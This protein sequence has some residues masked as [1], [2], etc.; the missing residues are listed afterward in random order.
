MIICAEV[1]DDELFREG[2]QYLYRQLDFTSFE[3]ICKIIFMGAN[4]RIRDLLA[5]TIA[6]ID[7]SSFV[8]LMKFAIDNENNEIL[9]KDLQDI[10]DDIN[11]NISY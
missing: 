7:D 6:H 11:E 8:P 3:K 9:K 10:L 1:N 2:I 5:L 4:D